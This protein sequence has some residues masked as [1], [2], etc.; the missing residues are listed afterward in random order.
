MY[1]QI[2]TTRFNA[3][4]FVPQA[5]N[6]KFKAVKLTT[7]SEAEVLTFLAQ[8]P[9][10]TVTMTG[11]IRDNGLVSPAHRGTFYGVRNRAGELEGV[12]LIG[13]ATLMETRTERA[14]AAFAETAQTCSTV[15]MILGEQERVE[16][17]WYYCQGGRQQMRLACR[18]SLFELRY[19]VRVEAAVPG[20]RPAQLDELD[21]VVPI[22]ARM[23]LEESGI[24]PLE[25]DAE[26]FRQ[27]CQ[28]RIE[29]GRTWVLVADGELLF[30]ADIIAD[31]TEVIYLEGVWTSEKIRGTGLGVNCMSQLAQELLQRTK[32]ISLLV[33]ERNMRAQ[34]FYRKCGF[35]FLTTYDTIFLEQ[36]DELRPN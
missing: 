28:R 18:E 30:K 26:G 22:Q 24:N 25:R 13:H 16:E 31:T 9:L 3:S 35:R 4:A 7:E 11:F 12:A 8:R 27:R 15:N 1:Q 36:E 32:S 10:H 6:E 2:P 21:L 23:A 34:A 29:Q 19:P 14:V 20:L 5:S 33:D 17:F